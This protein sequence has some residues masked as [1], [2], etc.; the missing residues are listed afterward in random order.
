MTSTGK[1]QTTNEIA[2]EDGVVSDGGSQSRDGEELAKKDTAQANDPWREVRIT[3]SPIA[4]CNFDFYRK[5]NLPGPSAYRSLAMRS[6]EV[7]INDSIQITT[8]RC[9][10]ADPFRYMGKARTE[11]RPLG[12]IQG[13]F[14][15]YGSVEGLL[16][17][18][19]IEFYYLHDAIIGGRIKIEIFRYNW[20]T[21]VLE[22]MTNAS[23]KV[24]LTF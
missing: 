2:Q 16:T 5:E 7:K 10:L 6:T 1:T 22:S 11:V 17:G 8:F 24:V 21:I 19:S 18:D 14:T 20:D 15:F 3:I 9:A 13:E 12:P 23:K 4:S